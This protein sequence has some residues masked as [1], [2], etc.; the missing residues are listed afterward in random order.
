MIKRDYGD[1]LRAERDETTN[2]MVWS[3][4]IIDRCPGCKIEQE[5]VFTTYNNPETDYDATSMAEENYFRDRIGQFCYHCAD[6]AYDEII[7]IEKT[8]ALTEMEQYH[9]TRLTPVE[10]GKGG[11]RGGISNEQ[12][13]L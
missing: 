6:K 1:E 9:K 7:E 2:S 11:E 13:K 5:I 12:K 10:E 4:S 3:R 8:R